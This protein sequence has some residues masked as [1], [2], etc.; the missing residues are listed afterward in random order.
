MIHDYGPGRQ[1]ASVHV[2]MAAENDVIASHDVIDNIE[3][4]FS[5][6]D[7]LQLIVHFD[8]ISTKDSTANDLSS[9]LAEEVKIIH[10][11][12][13]IH[14]LRIVQEAKHTNLIF[15]CVKPNELSMTDDE[16][17]A[18]ISALVKKE[19]P[20]YRC[21]ITVDRSYASFSH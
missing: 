6:N 19:H 7:D 12:L 21:M 1:F 20:D 9:W 5:E 11:E 16:I 14:D 15:D 3:H 17:K 4:D 2:E 8:P 13:A 18:A 10:N